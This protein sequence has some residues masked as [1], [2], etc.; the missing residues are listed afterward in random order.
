M[1]IR[2]NS[3]HFIAQG[4]NLKKIA[5]VPNINQGKVQVF[6]FIIQRLD[7]KEQ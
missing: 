2:T 4:V 3:K 6:Q 1:K 7:T 5:Q